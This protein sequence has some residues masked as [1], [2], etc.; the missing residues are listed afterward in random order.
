MRRHGVGSQGGGNGEGRDLH[1]RA[2]PTLVA[3]MG[4]ITG[5][6]VG[7]VDGGGGQTLPGQRLPQRDPGSRPVMLS[8]EPSSMTKGEGRRLP[9]A[10]EPQAGEGVSDR[11]GDPQLIARPSA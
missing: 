9:I 10:E 4:Q 6:P 2:D 3:E 8:H 7:E 11:A 5:E 1:F